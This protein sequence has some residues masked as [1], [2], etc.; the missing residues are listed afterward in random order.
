MS[1]VS[2]CM[3][4][5]KY[6]DLVYRNFRSGPLLCPSVPLH[7]P[8]VEWHDS[9]VSNGAGASELNICATRVII[10][11]TPVAAAAAVAISAQQQQ[12]LHRTCSD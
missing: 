11:V 9:F 10:D 2:W 12:H 6:Q 4:M 5:Q 3:A 8:K 1:A 7:S